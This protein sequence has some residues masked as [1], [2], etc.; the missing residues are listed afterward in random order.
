MSTEQRISFKIWFIGYGV[1]VASM[2]RQCDVRNACI[3]NID[4]PPRPI[5]VRLNLSLCALF[6]PSCEY[7]GRGQV[8]KIMQ[9]YYRGK[10]GFEA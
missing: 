2:T 9:F 10:P 5:E 7:N 1:V 8:K 4:T 3:D 6:Q